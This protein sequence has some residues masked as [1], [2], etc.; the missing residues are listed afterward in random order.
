MKQELAAY[1]IQ[2][3]FRLISRQAACRLESDDFHKMWLLRLPALLHK[4]L[5]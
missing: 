1:L 4:N 5:V 2:L 3:M